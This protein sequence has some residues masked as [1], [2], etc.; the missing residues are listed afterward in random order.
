MGE[1]GARMVM[2]LAKDRATREM[3][4]VVDRSLERAKE[5]RER[6]EELERERREREERLARREEKD[7]FERESLEELRERLERVAD[8][9]AQREA[10]RAAAANELATTPADRIDFTG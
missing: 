9:I 4:E 10:E 6:R 8:Q 7:R 5:A 3:L 2:A 1:Q